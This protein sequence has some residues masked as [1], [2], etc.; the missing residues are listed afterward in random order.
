VAKVFVFDADRFIQPTIVPVK[1]HR[2]IDNRQETDHQPR[3]P[4][5]VGDGG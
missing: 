5:F 2:T 3:L 4:I 1:D